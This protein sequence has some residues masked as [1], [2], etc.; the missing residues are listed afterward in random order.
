M[1]PLV[2]RRQVRIG[3]LCNPESPNGWYRGIA[4]MLA[5]ARRGHEIRQVELLGGELR[6]EL[7]R[8]CDV[9][10]VHRRHDEDVQRI[11]RYAKESGIA[12]VWDDDDDKTSVPKG[13]PAYRDY[14]GAKGE[15]IL[16]GVR[17]MVQ[18]A[19][20]V[21]TP[22]ERLTERFLQ[23]GAGRVTL[24]ENYVEDDLLTSRAQPR[25][26]E[27][28]VGWVAGGE[29]MMDVERV[30]IAEAVGRLL[31]AHETLRVVSVG[32]GLGLRHERYEHV[33]GLPLKELPRRV[34]EFDVGLAVIAD[35]PFNHGRSNVK[36]KE[37]AALGIPWL[38]SPIG[39]YAGMGEKQGGRLVPDDG[40]YE[41]IERLV[42]DARARRKLAKR[43]AKWGRTQTIGANVGLWEAALEDAVARA[44]V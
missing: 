8:G 34:R 23:L 3:F 7:V 22:S 11:V 10:H 35:I 21:T 17:W 32:T 24:I 13:H 27:V 37:Y 12:V 9:V 14:G 28:V 6:S 26:G 20:L 4:P 44:R 33:K 29:H 43:S 16:A 36:L 31:D 18:A 2:Y 39:P 15:R 1:H 19:D 38:A 42:L 5:L 25:A 30:P 41:G 40:W